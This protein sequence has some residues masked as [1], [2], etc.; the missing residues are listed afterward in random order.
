MNAIGCVNDYMSDLLASILWY[1][2]KKDKISALLRHNLGAAQ[3]LI[4]YFSVAFNR[5][6]FSCLSADK[7][8]STLTMYTI[9]LTFI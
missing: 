8:L 3:K 4:L 2:D 6:S 7:F 9:I 1:A 5:T